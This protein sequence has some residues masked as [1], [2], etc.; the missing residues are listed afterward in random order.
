MLRPCS[1]EHI[2]IMK[3]LHW[4]AFLYGFYPNLKSAL[5]L[6]RAFLLRFYRSQFWRLQKRNTNPKKR[7]KCFIGHNFGDYKNPPDTVHAWE[8]VLSVTILETTKTKCTYLPWRC[9]FYR[10]QFWRLQKLQEER[11]SSR[12][13]F[14]G[15]NFGDYKNT[16]LS[17]SITL[18]VLSVTILETTKTDVTA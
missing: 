4:V 14:I 11:S 15:H 2:L 18:G 12:S 10:S 8:I 16:L 17:L 5:W 6:Q 9:R 7:T 13:S 1:I 3:L